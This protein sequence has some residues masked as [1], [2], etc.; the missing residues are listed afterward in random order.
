VYDKSVAR[1]HPWHQG[2]LVPMQLF[3][4]DL[5]YITFSHAGHQP[6]PVVLEGV[7]RILK[8]ITFPKN[9][10]M[11]IRVLTMVAWK[12]LGGYDTAAIQHAAT[13]DLVTR[14]SFTDN[15][16]TPSDGAFNRGAYVYF[17]PSLYGAAGLFSL[18]D[19]LV[20]SYR[21]RYVTIGYDTAGKT[22]KA[23]TELKYRIIAMVSGFDEAPSTQL[24]ER[25]RSMMGLAEKGKVGY[26]VAVEQGAVLGTDYILRLDGK[27]KGFAGEVVLPQHIP[28]CVPIVV[29]NLNDR[30]TSV[31]YDRQAKRLRP[32]GM[33]DGKAYCHRALQER[34]G[35]IFIG[36]PFTLD[37]SE[38]CLSVVQTGAKALTIQ[39]HNPTDQPATVKVVRSRF[40]DFVACEDFSVSVPDGRTVERVVGAGKPG[41]RSPAR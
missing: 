38:L 6:A 18:T 28:V 21:N 35:K 30:W 39:V 23:G 10:R 1:A 15:R 22:F 40:F 33:H 20:Y 34:K 14:I 41:T 37:R 24:P 36:H 26:T 7:I 27:G 3:H 5:R 29:E 32:L 25:F 8:D 4:A 11:G 13:G 19:D 2:P 31:L 16:V 17:Y 12:S 9:Q